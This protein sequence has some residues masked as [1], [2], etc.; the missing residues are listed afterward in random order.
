M[1]S[2]NNR[3]YND[4]VSVDAPDIPTDQIV[5]AT[6]ILHALGDTIGF[7]DGDW[8]FNHYDLDKHISFDFANELIYEFIALGGVNRI[9][10]SDWSVSDDTLW[11]IAIAK[12]MI[13]YSSKSGIDKKFIDITRSNMIDAFNIAND[14][15][16][17]RAVGDMTYNMTELMSTEGKDARDYGYQRMGGGNGSAMRTAVIGLCLH[18]ESQIDELIDVSIT[19]SRMTHN[20]ALGYL[21]GFAMAYFTSLAVR[22]V[23]IQEWPFLLIEHLRSDRLADFI[24]KKVSRETRDY[25]DFLSDWERHVENR[26]KNRRIIKMKAFDNPMYRLK[27]YF[28]QFMYVSYEKRLSAQIGDTGILGV[29]MAYDAVLDSGGVWEKL[30]VYAMLHP[31]DSDTVG[32]MAGALFGAY[33]GYADVPEHMYAKLEFKEDLDDIA[34]KIH[35]K[36]F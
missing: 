16:V 25:M 24:E 19:T 17:D 29:I 32:A 10:L 7:K 22:K 33:Y 12:S 9:D 28:D 18:K 11:H 4:T 3:E 14:S 20:N 34:S 27:Y 35:K 31:G 23:D 5:S 13:A 6:I 2:S 21:G 8:E 30:I 36:Y 1:E 26:F 15:K